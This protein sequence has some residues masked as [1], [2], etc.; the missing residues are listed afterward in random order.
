MQTVGATQTATKTAVAGASAAKER[1]S[2]GQGG[3]GYYCPSTPRLFV[4]FL[5][6]FIYFY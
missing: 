4:S 2:S 3:V 6:P 5:F 1:S